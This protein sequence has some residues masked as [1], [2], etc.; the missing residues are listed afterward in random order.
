MSKYSEKGILSSL[1]K[2]PGVTMP[3]LVSLT[4]VAALIRTMGRFFIR[5]S[6]MNDKFH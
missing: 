2:G 6:Q 1:R 4:T 3:A 5:W